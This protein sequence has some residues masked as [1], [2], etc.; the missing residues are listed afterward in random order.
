MYNSTKV[1]KASEKLCE[2]ADLLHSPYFQHTAFDKVFFFLAPFGRLTIRWA[3]FV[4]G[5]TNISEFFVP[6]NSFSLVQILGDHIPN[7]H[8]RRAKKN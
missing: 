4:Q 2:E 3:L 8:A 1:R 7:R 6:D 5:S